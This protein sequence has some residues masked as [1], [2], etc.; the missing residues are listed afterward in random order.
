MWLSSPTMEPGP[1]EVLLAIDHTDPD[2]DCIREARSVFVCTCKQIKTG[3]DL[4]YPDT[5][6]NLLLDRTPA[7]SKRIDKGE[8]SQYG[9]NV[10]TSAIVHRH[11]WIRCPTV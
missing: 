6:I 10:I 9:A 3:L 11:H 4:A 7:E 5:I 8:K 1:P 2:P